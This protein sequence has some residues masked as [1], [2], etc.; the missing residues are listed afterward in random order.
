M[1]LFC[2][3]KITLAKSK[4]VT[5]GWSANLAESSKE[6][7]GSKRGSAN[8]GS[9]NSINRFISENGGSRFLR[10]AGNQQPGYKTSQAGG[11][12]KFQHRQL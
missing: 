6:G 7:C 9:A 4:E 1:A 12:Q 10:N 5:T 11:L 8:D 2:K 3:K